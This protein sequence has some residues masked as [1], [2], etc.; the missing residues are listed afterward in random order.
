[1]NSNKDTINNREKIPKLGKLL[2]PT[3]IGIEDAI[4]S[5]EANIKSPPE[6]P[7]EAFRAVTKIFMSACM[8][9]MYELQVDEDMEIEQKEQMAEAF[10]TQLHNLIKTFTNIDTFKLYE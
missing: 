6:Y 2:S 7:I 4:W 10:G 9:K 8:D 3:L 1:M 5:W